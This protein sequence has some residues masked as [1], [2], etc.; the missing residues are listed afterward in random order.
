MQN[1]LKQCER[2]YNSNSRIIPIVHGTIYIS[3]PHQP[4]RDCTAYLISSGM[5]DKSVR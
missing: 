2:V 1:L 4:H 5:N 3:G